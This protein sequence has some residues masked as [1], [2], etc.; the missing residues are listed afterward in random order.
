[1]RI[2]ALRQSSGASGGRSRKVAEVMTAPCDGTITEF[3]TGLTPNS[4]PNRIVS[5]PD[6]NLWFTTY[7]RSKVGRITTAL[8]GTQSGIVLVDDIVTTGATLAAVA[9]LL[10]TAGVVVRAAGVLAA[11]RRR[12]T[13]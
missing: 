5:G 13:P 10:G 3:T 1:M 8:D 2:S 6:G 9:H 4:G 12:H 11:T 7:D